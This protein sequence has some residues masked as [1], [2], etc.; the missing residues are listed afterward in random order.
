MSKLTAQAVRTAIGS[1]AVAMFSDKGIEFLKKRG[2][3]GQ[4]A[5][6][7]K[8]FGHLKAGDLRKGLPK[9]IIEDVEKAYGISNLNDA[10][11]AVIILGR[12][13]LGTEKVHE[14][15]RVPT[16]EQ[17]AVAEKLAGKVMSG[18]LYANHQRRRK[19]TPA[20]EAAPAT[21]D[22]SEKATGTK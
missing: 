11:V 7:S 5:L 3:G 13:P 8:V 1:A 18:E 16:A 20:P 17:K 2:N 22:K 12:P 19:A 21:T 6:A 10:Q 4:G 15:S 14:A 9:T